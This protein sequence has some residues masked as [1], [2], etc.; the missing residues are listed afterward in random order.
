MAHRSGGVRRTA[1][2]FLNGTAGKEAAAGG[3]R[4]Y[5]SDRI[6][7]N[8]GREREREVVGNSGGGKQDTIL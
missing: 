7:L 3:G 2:A 4:W 8:D 1:E 5:W 6:I